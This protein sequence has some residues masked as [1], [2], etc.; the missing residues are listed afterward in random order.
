MTTKKERNPGIDLLRIFAMFSVVLLHIL[1]QG[2]VLDAAKPLSLNYELAWFLECAAYCAVNC[3]ALIS[4]YVGIDHQHKFTNILRLW[5]QAAFYTVGFSLLF[6]LA[7][8]GSVSLSALVKSFFPFMT[9][10]YWYLTAYA[11]LFFFI[12]VLNAAVKNLPKRQLGLTLCGL[13]LLFSILTVLF[14]YDPFNLEYGYS[15]LWLM[16]LYLLGAYAKKYD[17]FSK[18][19]RRTLALL[20]LAGVLLTWGAKL[21]LEVVTLRFLGH[22]AYGS[23]LLLYT[24]PTVVLSAVSLLGFF[25]KQGASSA[26]HRL[27]SFV[28]PAAFGVYLIHANTLVW[29]S[30]LEKR[31]SAYAS[32]SAPALFAAVLLTATGIF[33]L[34]ALLDLLRI[35]LFQL[36][37]IPQILNKLEE[38]LQTILCRE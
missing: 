12:P 17:I 5:L 7:S 29:Q 1:G 4:G 10:Q 19:S 25:S 2:G 15:S 6:V 9:K 23:I 36:I 14:R 11:G 16:T 38:K 26:A 35:K 27:I 31:F 30:F 3:Y 37:K 20:Y 33:I 28:A 34:C 18:L 24:S 13:L 21:I 32:L 22:A 8:P